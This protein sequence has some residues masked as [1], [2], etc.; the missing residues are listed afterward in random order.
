[1]LGVIK[2]TSQLGKGWLRDEMGRVILFEVETD[3]TG[4]FSTFRDVVRDTFV[5]I[6]H[7]EN[8]LMCIDQGAT[9]RTMLQVKGSWH[10]FSILG[11]AE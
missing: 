4:S 9:T 2:L 1:M 3:V 8:K 6:D 7:D 10:G 11:S 5:G